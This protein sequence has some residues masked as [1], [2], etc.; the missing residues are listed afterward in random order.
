[1]DHQRGR[2]DITE[3]LDLA[4]HGVRRAV[5]D[6]VLHQMLVGELALVRLLGH[7]AQIAPDRAAQERLHVVGDA[8][9]ALLAG[10]GVGRRHIGHA[11]HIHLAER[12]VG[13]ERG[14][15]LRHMLA[16]DGDML[17]DGSRRRQGR[18]HQAE[19]V[20][21]C[22]ADRAFRAGTHVERRVRLLDRLREHLV[23]VVHLDPEI[24]AVGIHPLLV[25]A[26]ENERNRLRLNFAAFLVADAEALE[27]IGPVAGAEAELEAP[28]AQDI[29]EGRI[30]DNAHG[31]VQRHDHDGGA[32]L[33]SRRPRSEIGEIAERVRQDAVLVGE[34][35]FSDPHA[36]EAEL[37]RFQ[38][39]AR[40]ALVDGLV[41]IGF[42]LRVRM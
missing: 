39:F 33:D 10:P 11:H 24:L 9:L 14:R 30:L 26:V 21:R 7:V 18:L 38:D 19:A 22:H 37:L 29:D 1:M 42:G 31:M 6:G 40:G 32:Q 36:V 20:P 12:R 4:Q 25:E 35:V 17:A 16:I 15:R 2:A 23:D 5:Q 34:V 41:R 27:L 8:G 28:V 3:G 13:V